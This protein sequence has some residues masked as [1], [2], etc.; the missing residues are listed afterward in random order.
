M[1]ADTLTQSTLALDAFTHAW[2]A[3][4]AGEMIG[5]FIWPNG[6]GDRVFRD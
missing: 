1:L 4:P 6:M 5:I 2:I 3:I